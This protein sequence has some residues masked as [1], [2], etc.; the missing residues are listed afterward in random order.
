ME[1]IAFS[2][3]LGLTFTHYSP[4]GGGLPSIPLSGDRGCPPVTPLLG[5]GSL[6]RTGGIHPAVSKFADFFIT[7]WKLMPDQ[8]GLTSWP[9]QFQEPRLP[10]FNPPV[11]RQGVSTRYSPLGGGLPS[12]PLSEYRGCPPV[13]PL[14]GAGSLQSPCLETGGVHPLLPS[15][16]RAPFNRQR[17]STRPCQNSQ[18][19]SS[20]VGS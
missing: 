7:G 17:V 15:W 16:G 4:L 20:Q 1:L 3:P 9:P 19:S 8:G 18:T 12:I 14:L 2:E 6:Q 5:A 11:R 13:T 10:P